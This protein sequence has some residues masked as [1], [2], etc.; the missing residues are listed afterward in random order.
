MNTKNKIITLAAIVLS[1]C[2]DLDF[3]VFEVPQPEGVKNETF[4]PKKLIGSYSSLTDSSTLVITKRHIISFE[5]FH[6]AA[7]LSDLDS[8]DRIKLKNDTTL[9]EFDNEMKVV[10]MIKR[11]SMFQC[12]ID[13]DTLLDI[14]NERSVLRKFKGY[15]FLNVETSNN[16]WFVN[17]LGVTRNGLIIGAI[18]S[19]ED[20]KNL[21]ELTNTKS[22]T[23]YN[24][25]P[26]RKE[27]KRF[28]KTN[29]FNDE[30]RYIKVERDR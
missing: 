13:P 19:K 8:A 28:L 23:V 27:L 10:T 3:V 25:K 6:M 29:G 11:D 17:K 16:N 2:L 14:L 20:L 18:S 5:H 21:R 9:T 22:D 7:P 15:Y 1:S 30:K 4:I 12:T 26:T 24:F